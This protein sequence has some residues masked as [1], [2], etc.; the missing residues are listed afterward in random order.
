MAEQRTT[1]FERDI[2]PLFT[3]VDINH[4]R[5]MEVLL[6]DY[7]YMSQRENAETVRD[8]ITG[9]EQPQMPPSGPYW[10]KERI[11]LLS[12]WIA[13]GCPP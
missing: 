3:P 9:K 1:S 6:D 4:M 5:P 2:R 11:E 8:F 12:R 7:G 13:E 10:P